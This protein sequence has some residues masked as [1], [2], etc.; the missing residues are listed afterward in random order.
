MFDYFRG[1]SKE[2]G[3][4]GLADSMSYLDPIGYNC[5]VAFDSNLGVEAGFLEFATIMGNVLNNIGYMYTDVLNIVPRPPTPSKRT[6]RTLCPIMSEISSSA[7]SGPPTSPLKFQVLQGSGI[8]E[9][10]N[11]TSALSISFQ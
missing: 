8:N 11:R 10:P 1:G 9:K 2:Q 6:T 7:G 5:Y 4:E 3:Y